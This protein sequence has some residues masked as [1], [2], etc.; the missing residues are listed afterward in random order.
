MAP[1]IPRE[2][3]QQFLADLQHHLAITNRSLP[4]NPA[5]F[6][7]PPPALGVPAQASTLSRQYLANL[8]FSFSVT[9]PV[10]PTVE[11]PLAM[12]RVSHAIHVRGGAGGGA[13]AQAMSAGA[14]LLLALL[15]STFL[16]LTLGS[17][18]VV[19]CCVRRRRFRVDQVRAR[20]QYSKC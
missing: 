14:A 8:S 16:V 17:L 19:L 4:L 10:L 13:D 2:R 6:R 11:E 7:A 15:S 18:L 5:I 9:D 1:S 3:L 20:A 12:P